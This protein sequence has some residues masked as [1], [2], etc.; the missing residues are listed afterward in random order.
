MTITIA[1]PIV[2]KPTGTLSEALAWLDIRAGAET[3]YA[4]ELFRL[5]KLVGFDPAILFAQAAHETADFSSHWW[6]ARRNVAGIGITGDTAQ[7]EASHTWKNGIEAARAHVVHMCAYVFGNITHEE[8]RVE[9]LPY[10]NL[11]PRWNAVFDAG[12]MGTVHI[13]GD[14]GSG[15]WATDPN[16]APQIAAKANA[17]FPNPSSNQ[18]E[19][20][21]SDLTFGNVPYPPVIQSHL[22]GANPWVET[23]GAPDVPLAVVWHRM[24]GT[25]HGTD[26]WF[27]GNHA[28]T[29]YGVAVRAIDGDEAGKIFEWIAPRSG[30]YGESSGP[31]DAPYG[32]GLALVNEVGVQS[33][34]RTTKAIEISGEYTTPLDDEAR[35]AIVA[36]TAYWA[37]QA[38]IPWHAFPM[39]P[40]KGRS[41]VIWH[42]EITIGS[43]K[44]CPGGVV[45]SE[46]N[47]LIQRVASLLRQYQVAAAPAEPVYAVPV[48][49]G[50]WD[51][52]VESPWPSDAKD[53]ELTFKVAR[54]K[55]TALENAQRYPDFAVGTKH[56]GVA[57]AAG[58]TIRVERIVDV[59]GE[60]WIVEPEG[61]HVKAVGFTPVIRLR[62]RKKKA[63]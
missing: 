36:M 2:G 9:L 27:H 19:S 12:F 52:G 43:G 1:S 16:Y 15:K 37:D 49:P 59:D 57:I 6:Q 38:R 40:G 50:W 63:A 3:E 45:M 32:D 41:F 48:L 56:T 18:E 33:V 61:H 25:F 22:P 4:E 58:E 42:Q 14:L 21:M 44:V 55:V 5:C 62:A 35:A 26:G 31:V 47:A 8:P 46:T 17:I 24:L 23:S 29:C 39:V 13:L 7:N 28:A 30:W 11:D 54:R 60:T 10:M 53:G 34:N 51:R 20:S